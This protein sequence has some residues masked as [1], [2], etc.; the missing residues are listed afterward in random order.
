MPCILLTRPRDRSEAFAADIA[1]CG[2][3]SMIW[4]L[5]TIQNRLSRPVAPAQDQSL[6]FTSV[7]AVDAL[8]DPI[9]TRTPAICVGPA[10]SAAARRRGFAAV[11]DVG[12]DADDLVRSLT[13]A[14]PR[15]YIHL[16]GVHSRGEVA[17]RLT[18]A[19]RP[20]D[21]TIVYEA[22]ASRKAPPTIDTAFQGRKIQAVALFSP[23]SAAIFERVAGDGWLDG[24]VTAFAISHAAAAPVRNMGFA[25]VIVAS[26]PDGEAMRAAICSAKMRQRAIGLSG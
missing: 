22:V 3:T 17:A 2:W 11:T 24:Q 4:P 7:R 9:P 16:R 8:P 20:T 1:D 15:R 14:P 21:E 10:T 12:G 6:I 13:N 19:G 25:K 23:R 18:A 26:Q 5:L